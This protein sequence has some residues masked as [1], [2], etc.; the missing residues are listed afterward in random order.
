M[1]PKDAGWGE[2]SLSK[3]GG[4]KTV[5]R[6]RVST[7]EPGNILNQ[8]YK[9]DRKIGQGA[10]AVVFS[11][12]DQRTG[13]HVA[14]KQMGMYVDS[15]EEKQ[16]AIQ[17]FEHEAQLLHTLE[18][19][20]IPRVYEWFEEGSERYLVMDFVDGELLSRRVDITA[21]PDI[22]PK[23]LPTP[24]QVVEWAIQITRALQYLHSQKPRPVIYKDLKPDN[25]MV[26]RDGKIM[27]LDFGIAKGR[28]ARGQYK[29]ILKGMV[30]PG[31]A[32]PEQYSG[33]ATDP[34]TDLYALGA[35][36]YVLLTGHVPPQSIDRHQKIFARQADPLVPVQ[37]FN[38][39]VSS[40]LE[41]LVV[42][43]MAL[44]RDQRLQS[45]DVVLRELEALPEC[46][47][48]GRSPR[49]LDTGLWIAV[50]LLVVLLTVLA[51]WYFSRPK[52]VIP[53]TKPWPKHAYARPLVVSV[54]SA[55]GLTDDASTRAP[56]T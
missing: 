16:L 30:S 27:M 23:F 17:Q 8:R 21:K 43:L 24:R 52:R 42:R 22:T 28:D 7:L 45:A 56:Q 11:A 39:G 33:V 6:G 49:R 18:H 44:K 26:G 19:P 50:A 5:E 4:L 37:K 38:P 53:G 51:T 25:L 54:R 10:M 9:V 40:E 36:M 55:R 2:T 48:H 31:Y 15:P 3:G 41:M 47:R 32:A 14:I 35:T 13:K 29:T 1:S 46:G 34:R 20:N 12:R